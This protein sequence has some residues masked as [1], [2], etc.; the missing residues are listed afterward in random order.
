MA[1]G[2]ATPDGNGSVVFRTPADYEAPVVQ[3]QEEASNPLAEAVRGFDPGAGQGEA[4]G[5]GAMVGG[6]AKKIEFDQLVTNLEEPLYRR[7]SR[8]LRFE[9]ER[10]GQS[11]DLS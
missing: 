10:R 5:I 1:A 7:L 2:L 11:A 3:R 6:L 8:R 4:G 9:R